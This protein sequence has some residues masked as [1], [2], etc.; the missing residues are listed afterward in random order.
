[1]WVIWTDCG[2]K[3]SITVIFRLSANIPAKHGSTTL[4]ANKK[5]ITLQANAILDRNLPVAIFPS[6]LPMTPLAPQSILVSNLLT[7]QNT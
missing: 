5:E 4:Q 3:V 6:P 7:P 2:S 1:M